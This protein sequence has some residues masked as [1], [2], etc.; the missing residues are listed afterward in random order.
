[1]GRDIG[2]HANRDTRTAANQQIG[3]PGRQDDRLLQAVV[4]VG[5]EAYGILIDVGKANE[6]YANSLGRAASSLTDAE[7]KTAFLNKALE[8]G[9][10]NAEA[11]GDSGENLTDKWEVKL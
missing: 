5:H 4:K 9:K 6:E 8:I 3:Q 11:A 7:K 1:M 2:R 10:K